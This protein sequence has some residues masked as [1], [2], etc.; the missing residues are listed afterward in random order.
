MAAPV[1]RR[2]RKSFHKDMAYINHVKN[3]HLADVYIHI[4]VFECTDV[5]VYECVRT[6][7]AFG[8]GHC[9]RQVELGPRPPDP[10]S[11]GLWT[12]IINDC[13]EKEN[14]LKSSLSVR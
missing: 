13:G 12:T 3:G 11:D 6:N 5:S 4:Y 1:R 10:L 2:N 9:S 14:N 7:R 8:T